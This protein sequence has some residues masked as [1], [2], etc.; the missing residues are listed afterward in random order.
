MALVVCHYGTLILALVV[1][2]YGTLI[3]APL[4]A[5]CAIMALHICILG[6]R[7]ISINCPSLGIV[8]ECIDIA[9]NERFRM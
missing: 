8:I 2:Y 3:M 9:E 7:M 5:S 4:N 1:C 6:T